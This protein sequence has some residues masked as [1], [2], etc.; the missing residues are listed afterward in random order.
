M[1]VAQVE[2][3]FMQPAVLHE[4]VQEQVQH[5]I[6]RRQQ[7]DAQAV[8]LV[9]DH[10][11]VDVAERQQSRFIEQGDMQVDRAHILRPG[12]VAKRVRGRCAVGDPLIA[13][14]RKNG[15]CGRG[16]VGRHENIKVRHHAARRVRIAARHQD[17]RALE[18][19]RHDAA[20]VQRGDKLAQL[21]LE[22]AI[23]DPVEA[24]ELRQVSRDAV[25]HRGRQLFMAQ[26]DAQG[27]REQGA[28]GGFQQRIPIEVGPRQPAGHVGIRGGQAPAQQ[29]M[30]VQRRHRHSRSS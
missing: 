6:G 28:V 5:A 9:I 19:K 14:T 13:A 2:A 30:Q 16:L 22:P 18:Q 7:P 21:R 25:R 4:V 20:P 27:R 29:A 1:K 10:A 26:R 24:G 23:A 17:G 12:E 15:E 3:P 11:R 8:H